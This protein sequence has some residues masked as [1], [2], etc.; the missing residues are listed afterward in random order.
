MPLDRVGKEYAAMLYQKRLEAILANQ[1]QEL[2]KVVADFGR[3]NLMQSRMYLS[4]RAKVIGKHVGLMAEAMAQT[5][6]QAYERAGQT[7]NQTILQEITA[8]VNQFCEAQKRNVLGAANNMV[9]QNFQGAPQG[10]VEALAGEMERQLAS[11][12]ANATR[13]LAIKHH[14][15]LLDQGR[16]AL[17]GYA[18]AMGKQWDVF[19]SHASEDKESFVR[20]LAGALEETG[21]Q[22]WFDA[23]ALTVGTACGVRL[24]RVY[25]ILA[26][27]SLS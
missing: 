19:I 5:L 27:E 18:A 25:P 26:A 23:T 21:L 16:A 9:S 2:Q 14:E 20:P 4:A 17:K 10:M 6:L 8:E 13:D 1:G 22:V 7:L 3:R 15:I 11:V 24:T 12:A